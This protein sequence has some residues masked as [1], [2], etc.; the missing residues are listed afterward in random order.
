MGAL[1]IAAPVLEVMLLGCYLW[2]CYAAPWQSQTLRP[3]RAPA[4]VWLWI[5]GMLGM[6]AALIVAHLGWGLGF[7]A[8]LKSS[9]GWMKGWALLA[10]FPLCGACLRIRPVIVVRAMM[11]LAVQ[12]L[13]LMPVLVGAALAHLPERLF[14][15]PLQAIGGPGPEFFTVYLYTID[16]ESGALRWQFI[17][18]W[19]PAAGMIGNMIFIFAAFERDRRLRWAG[20]IAAI[21]ICFMTK[22]RMAILFLGLY[23]PMIWSISRLSRPGAQLA[24]AGLSLIGG[25]AADAVIQFVQNSIGAFRAARASSTRVREMLGKIAVHRWREEAPVFGHGVVQRGTHIVEHMPIGSHHTWYGLLYVKG[26][27]G[28]MSLAVPLCYALLEMC[29]LAQASALGRA[30][31]AFTFTLFYYSGGEN[32]EILAYLFWPGLLLLG[33]AHAEAAWPRQVRTARVYRSFA[34]ANWKRA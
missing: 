6:L 22:S 12:T 30:G 9:I 32:L 28:V 1:Y 26:L 7:G 25:I 16:P 15:S 5:A 13:L 3:R 11:W 34:G 8:T 21:L 17:A 27:I 31:L 24:C 14:I 10:V 29:L 2:R 23:P 20:T 19:S 18:P 4:G 33:A